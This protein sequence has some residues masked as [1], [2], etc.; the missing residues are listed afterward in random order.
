MIVGA[1][2]RCDHIF[3]FRFL[4]FQNGTKAFDF[5]FLRKNGNLGLGIRIS[6]NHEVNS[7]DK[8][9]T[10]D[11]SYCSCSWNLFRK[12]C[13]W[14]VF[15]FHSFRGFFR[16][17][18]DSEKKIILTL[19][20]RSIYDKWCFSYVLFV[21]RAT[22]VF[23]I[24][25]FCGSAIFFIASWAGGQKSGLVGGNRWIY[26]EHSEN[27]RKFVKTFCYCEVARLFCGQ[28]AG[29]ERGILE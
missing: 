7:W 4:R 13:N 12:C 23:A 8:N 28:K 20:F 29:I 9:N 10:C 2:V 5:H 6:W 24:V 14:K 25:G 1:G 16:E 11:F 26:G 15:D 21:K 17:L 19:Q 3:Q 18:A 27:L 22:A